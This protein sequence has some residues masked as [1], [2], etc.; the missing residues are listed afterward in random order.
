[1]TNP[2]STENLINEF[3]FPL[4]KGGPGSGRYPAGSG[5]LPASV[6]GDRIIPGISI[7]ELMDSVCPNMTYWG[8]W[9]GAIEISN[10]K[11]KGYVGY[12]SED[13]VLGDP[14][15]DWSKVTFTVKCD[16]PEKGD[17]GEHS[18]TKTADMNDI[19][20]AYTEYNKKWTHL[21]TLDDTDAIGTDAFWQLVF[22][23]RVVYG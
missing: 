15:V 21:G 2:F 12:V 3:E 14:N 6:S 20:R 5:S 8:T 9:F 19:A 17:D 10:G 7:P 22:Y 18:A 16:D 23:G 1:M 13:K 11:D 4:T